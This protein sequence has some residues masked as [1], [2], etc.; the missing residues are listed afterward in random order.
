MNTE[1]ILPQHL[2]PVTVVTVPM[3]GLFA[4]AHHF[5]LVTDKMGADGL[6]IV[7]ANSGDTGGPGERSWRAIVHGR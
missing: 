6:P 2:I 7:V 4:L 5:A 1:P 3:T